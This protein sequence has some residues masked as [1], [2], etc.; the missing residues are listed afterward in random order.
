MEQQFYG[1]MRVSSVEQNVERQRQELVRWGIVE[2]HI[3]TD[4]VSGKDFNR[5]SYQNMRKKLKK[6]DVLGVARVAGIMAVK[7]TSHL[8]PMCHPL[9][10]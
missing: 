7:Q 8:I 10:I 1:Y 4:K 2:K 9:M 6:G 3:Y 5:P